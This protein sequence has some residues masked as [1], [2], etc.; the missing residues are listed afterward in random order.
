MVTPEVALQA[1]P[2]KDD[3][4]VDQITMSS[5]ELFPASVPLSQQE[6][7]KRASGNVT[8][9]PRE[10][11][12]A[13]ETSS[14]CD[15]KEVHSRI[16]ARRGYALEER[17]DLIRENQAIKTWCH[18]HALEELDPVL[19]YL[20]QRDPYWSK[21]ENKYRIGGI[22]LLKETPR[23][24]ATLEKRKQQPQALLYGLAPTLTPDQLRAIPY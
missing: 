2:A 22:T 15:T 5:S 24:L 19:D 18:L 3:A 20:Q 7:V 12:K 17:V 11:K 9:K 23:V 1:M 6:A 10:H 14:K 13:D 21:P 16:N 4:H 8:R